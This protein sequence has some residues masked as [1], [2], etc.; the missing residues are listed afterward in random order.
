MTELHLSVNFLFFYYLVCLITYTRLSSF[1]SMFWQLSH[2]WIVSYLD[3]GQTS[4]SEIIFNWVYLHL[5]AAIKLF[6]KSIKQRSTIEQPKLIRKLSI[7]VI[8]YIDILPCIC[9]N[10]MPYNNNK[11]KCNIRISFHFAYKVIVNGS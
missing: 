5:L 2:S 3:H 8:E 6:H 11:L 9:T 10:R 1:V 4:Q 7:V